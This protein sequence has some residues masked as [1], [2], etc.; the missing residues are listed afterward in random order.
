MLTGMGL[1]DLAR[2]AKHRAFVA[3]KRARAA[4]FEGKWKALTVV[5]P[6]ISRLTGYEYDPRRYQPPYAGKPGHDLSFLHLDPPPV[7]GVGGLPRRVFVLWTG[8]VST[9]VSEPS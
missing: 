5:T 7:D 1:M 8:A 4:A 9:M 2:Q 6:P 3:Q